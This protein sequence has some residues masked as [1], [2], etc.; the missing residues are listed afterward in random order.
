LP[1]R[2]DDFPGKRGKGEGRGRGEE[3]RGRGVMWFLA[4]WKERFGETD[5]HWGKC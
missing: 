4:T 5:F 2:T 3:R 1:T